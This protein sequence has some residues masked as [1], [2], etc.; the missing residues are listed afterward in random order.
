MREAVEYYR[1]R[2]IKYSIVK[3]KIA[4]VSGIFLKELRHGLCI[5]KI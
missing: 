4:P 5:L 2:E 1:E 3:E